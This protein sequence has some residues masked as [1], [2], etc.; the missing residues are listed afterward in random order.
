MRRLARAAFALLLATL[1]AAPAGGALVVLE[2][3]RHLKVTAF[4]LV[5]ED[6][7]R[8]T[9]YGGG[10]IVLSIERVERI[11][12]DEIDPA[13]FRAPPVPE[14]APAGP[15]PSVRVPSGRPHAAPSRWAAI[16][17]SASA[18]HRLDPAFVA[19][20]IR[21]ESGWRPSAVSPKG[22]R[23]LMQLMPATARRLGVRRSFD[24]EQNIRGG[25]LYLSRLAERFG[26]REAEKVLAAYNAGEE[27]VGS[28][29]GIPP[30]RETRE[31]VRKVMAIW[32]GEA[33]G[34]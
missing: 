13:L 11:V 27:A 28:Y 24:P 26:E 9:L 18:A 30:Y 12:D 17:E 31:Y 34:S 33:P 1:A 21:V 16:V 8:L 14:P 32:T 5:G 3:G 2:E 20:V 23:G 6:R 4:E 7:I 19:A 25:T 10:E 22:A 29:G 15:R